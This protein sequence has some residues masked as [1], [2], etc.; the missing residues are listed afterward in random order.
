MTRC[1]AGRRAVG[2]GPGGRIL[3]RGRRLR[4]CLIRCRRR[5]G[6][7]T[8]GAHGSWE[9]MAGEVLIS[10]RC[11]V[12]SRVAKVHSEEEELAGTRRRRRRGLIL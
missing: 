12:G 9:E 7:R 10:P 4:R 11:A 1:L 3:F 6:L 8:C 5:L 2:G